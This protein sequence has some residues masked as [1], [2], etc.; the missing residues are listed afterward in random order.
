LAKIYGYPVSGENKKRLRNKD[1][2]LGSEGR[3]GAA[4]ASRTWGLNS[5]QI[6]L[7]AWRDSGAVAFRDAAR[8][9]VNGRSAGKG[10]RILPSGANG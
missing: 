10:R 3:G 8:R 9:P 2:E 5:F 7:R 1:I 6:G 4:A